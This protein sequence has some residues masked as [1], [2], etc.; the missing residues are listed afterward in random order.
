MLLERRDCVVIEWKTP[1]Q[2]IF[3][4]FL[5]PYFRWTWYYGTV[6]GDRGVESVF[7]SCFFLPSPSLPCAIGALICLSIHAIINSLYWFPKRRTKIM[8][9]SNKK[10]SVDRERLPGDVNKRQE[11]N[12]KRRKGKQSKLYTERSWNHVEK[13]KVTKKY[14]SVPKQY[15]YSTG[16]PA[17]NKD[18]Q[19]RKQKK[20]MYPEHST[21]N[22][23]LN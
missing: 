17:R 1:K 18:K 13:S 9:K 16:T 23:K 22:A 8:T 15:I 6:E 4:S 12:G 5:I 20:E 3:F 2:P 7:L 10:G 19:K 11:M 21:W 14:V